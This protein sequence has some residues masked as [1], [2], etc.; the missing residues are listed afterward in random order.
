MLRA[1]QAFLAGGFYEPLSDLLNELVVTAVNNVN[2]PTQPVVV[3]IGCGEGY[4]LRRLAQQFA[5][6]SISLF[7]VDIAKTAVRVTAKQLGKDAHCLVADVNNRLPFTDHSVQV[8][9]NLFA[10]RNAIE[11]ARL[12]VPG[13]TLL[14]VVPAQDHLESLRQHL[15]LLGMQAEKQA[16]ITAQFASSF[17]LQQ[18]YQLAYPMLLTG[19]ALHALVRMMPSIRHLPDEQREMLNHLPQVETV[20]SFLVLQFIRVGSDRLTG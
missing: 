5:G 19:K 2:K 8:L 10:P 7:G 15:R 6:Q 20:A 11:F 14:T 9:T 16:H 1:R 4:Y 13:G 17:T 12:V 18:V 3:D